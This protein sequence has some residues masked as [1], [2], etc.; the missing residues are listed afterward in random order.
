MRVLLLQ[1]S[2]PEAEQKAL[3]IR[4]D[5]DVAIY[6]NGRAVLNTHIIPGWQWTNVY[7]IALTADVLVLTAYNQVRMNARR[8]IQSNKL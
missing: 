2:H 1:G 7:D 5:D 4:V 3:K 8:I 6:Q